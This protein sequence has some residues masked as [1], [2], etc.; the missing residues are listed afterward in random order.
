MK[1]S[2]RAKRASKSVEYAISLDIGIR[3]ATLSGYRLFSATSLSAKPWSRRSLQ[4]R[5]NS[6]QYLTI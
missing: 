3:K 6:G 5:R 4:L 2:S 1:S